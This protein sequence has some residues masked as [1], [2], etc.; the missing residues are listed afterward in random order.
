MHL[1]PAVGGTPLFVRCAIGLRIRR[2]RV[3]LSEGD[4]GDPVLVDPVFDQVIAHRLAARL[5]R[6]LIG[7]ARTARIAMGAQDDRTALFDLR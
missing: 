7:I 3:L 2:N 5:G 4:D 6:A 1:D